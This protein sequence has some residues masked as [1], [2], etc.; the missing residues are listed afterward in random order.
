[1]SFEYTAQSYKTH[2]RKCSVGRYDF[3]PL[4]FCRNLYAGEKKSLNVHKPKHLEAGHKE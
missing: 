2:F 1:M 4:M 3:I